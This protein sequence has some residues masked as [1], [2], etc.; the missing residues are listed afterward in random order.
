MHPTHDLVWHGDALDLLA[1]LPA[2]SVDAV[3]TD[4]PYGAQL[5]PDAHPWDVWPAAAVWTEIARVLTPTGILAVTIAPHLAHARI[6]DVLAAGFQV[7]EV[8]FWV[9]GSG[10]PVYR[11]RLKRCYDLVYLMS[12]QGRHLFPAQARGAY[13]AGHTPTRQRSSIHVRTRVIGGQ[14]APAPAARST[15]QYGRRMHPANVACLPGTPAFGAQPHYDQIFAIPRARGATD[16]PRHPTAK[17]L[18]LLV[19]LVQLLTPPGGCVLDPFCGGG[20]TGEA[21]LLTGRRFLGI[22]RAARYVDLARTRLAAA[23]ATVARRDAHR[24]PPPPPRR[25]ATEEVSL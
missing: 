19:H 11:T 5:H 3:I 22:E 13:R 24:P 23:Q 18:D 12:R 20:T 15:Y 1:R 9:S 4:P 21:A 2:A 14:F 8:L 7:L 16:L 17:P 6:P 10:R 25:N